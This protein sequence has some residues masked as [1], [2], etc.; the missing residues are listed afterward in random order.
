VTTVYLT[1]AAVLVLPMII[2]TALLR[3][4]H[5]TAAEENEHG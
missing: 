4:N 1:V 5:G 3:R 2:V